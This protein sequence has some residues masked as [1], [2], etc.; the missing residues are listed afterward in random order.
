[1]RA[2]VTAVAV[3]AALTAGVAGLLACGGCMNVEAKV[4]EAAAAAASGNWTGAYELTE[5]CLKKEPNNVTALIL[6]GLAQSMQGRG[7]EA[8]LVLEQAAKLA[9][10]DFAAQYFHGWILAE[11]GRYADALVPLRQAHALRPTQKNLLVLLARCCLEQNLPEGVRY[12]QAMR[13]FP[14]LEKGPELYNA[15]GVLWL[16]QGQYEQ[17]RSNFMLAWQRDNSS[18]IVP[19]NLAVLYD[20]YLRNPTEA[21]RYYRYCL[22]ANQKLGNQLRASLIHERVLALSKEVPR[23]APRP[24]P[25]TTRP[26]TTKP[27]ATKPATT[28][29]TRR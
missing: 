19:Q 23:T 14:E 24:A 18:V 9:P 6:N 1:M 4:E 20:H 28:T 5:Q 27:A 12:L 25:T 3:A 13:R 16:N 17:A 29:R 21:L 10:G 2:K 22:G 7:L 11:N 8:T 26:G 15:L